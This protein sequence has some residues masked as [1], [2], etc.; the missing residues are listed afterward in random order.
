MEKRIGKRFTQLASATNISKT[1]AKVLLIHGTNDRIVPFT[2]A[3]IIL[4]AANNNQAE[5]WAITGKGHSNCHSKIGFWDR[6]IE[7]LRQ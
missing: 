2:Q 4:N 1:K 7:F 3:N 6:I 5:L